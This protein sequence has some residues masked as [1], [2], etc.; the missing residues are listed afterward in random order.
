MSLRTLLLIIGA[1]IVVAVYVFTALKR[2]RDARVHYDRRFRMDVPD[3]ILRHDDDTEA[4]EPPRLAPRGEGF[5]EIIAIRT[6]S[7]DEVPP[8]R[9]APRKGLLGKARDAAAAMAQAAQ[10]SD[11]RASEAD[12]AP[13]R[14]AAVAAPAIDDEPAL[15]TI[16]L[17]NDVVL[18]PQDEALAGLPAVRNDVVPPPEPSNARKRTDQLDLFGAPADA[19][20]PEPAAVRRRTYKEPSAEPE[21]GLISLYVRAHEG[22][23]FSGTT[24][25]KALNSVGMQF[26]DMAIFHHFGAGELKCQTPVFSAANMFEPGTFDM[27]R[28]EAFR[29]AGVALFLQ[30]PG[31][32]DGPVA[33]ELLLNTAQRL[34]ELTGGELY[35]DPKNLLDPPS[36]AR[37]RKRAARFAHGRQ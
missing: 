20:P 1:V 18:P 19:A 9:P 6:L 5:D 27:R 31:P 37:L 33:F 14:V 22:K 15:A 17:P 8:V 13:A 35:V 25:V 16:K 24:L 32:L 36:I 34:T 29:T 10:G 2:R 28:I 21:S 4:G 12:P 23:E 3:A 11:S 30:L 7:P 26:G